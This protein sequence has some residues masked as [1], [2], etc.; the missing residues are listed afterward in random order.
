MISCFEQLRTDWAVTTTSS[1]LTPSTSCRPSC[2][3]EA[4]GSHQQ[5]VLH[6]RLTLARWLTVATAR[7]VCSLHRPPDCP[8]EL[9]MLLLGWIEQSV[10]QVVEAT[11]SLAAVLSTDAST[12]FHHVTTTRTFPSTSSSLQRQLSAQANFT[13]R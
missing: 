9:D 10:Q 1:V 3:I 6:Q 5:C 12:F 13:L 11:P 7:S 2:D 4:K 8:L